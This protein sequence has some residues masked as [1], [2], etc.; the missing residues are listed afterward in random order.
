M[1]V[2][3]HGGC[4]VSQMPV[5]FQRHWWTSLGRAAPSFLCFL[6]L[7]FPP[8]EIREV[9]ASDPTSLTQQ[10]YLLP[11][12]TDHP[13]PHIT[14]IDAFLGVGFLPGRMPERGQGS[15]F[16]R[17]NM[18]VRKWARPKKKKKIPPNTKNLRKKTTK[19]IKNL[20]SDN[21]KSQQV[22]VWEWLHFGINTFHWPQ[23]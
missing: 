2:P 23:L 5:S 17:C 1:K 19:W 7:H 16:W 13:K 11:N 15:T 20:P 10:N 21:L 18:E 6:A 3:Y 4:S 14:C 12:T 22:G 9:S 8:N